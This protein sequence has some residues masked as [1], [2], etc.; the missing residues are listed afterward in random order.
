MS[1]NGDELWEVG[2]GMGMIF[3]PKHGDGRV[4]RQGRGGDDGD[5]D[6]GL[7]PH[8]TSLLSLVPFPV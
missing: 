6:W 8:P 4:S 7:H 5:E 1:R 2:L 3:I